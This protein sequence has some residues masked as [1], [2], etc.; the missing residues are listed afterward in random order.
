MTFKKEEKNLN[1]VNV[2][3]LK[4]VIRVLLY[5]CINVILCLYSFNYSIQFT[6]YYLF[7]PCLKIYIISIIL[8]I[9]YALYASYIL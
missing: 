6:L 4:N 2:I 7:L 5:I 8:H 3:V 9:F 1:G